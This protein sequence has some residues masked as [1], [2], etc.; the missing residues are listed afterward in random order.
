MVRQRGA[1][2]ADHHYRGATQL[3]IERVHVRLVATHASDVLGA[4]RAGSR[5]AFVA[6]SGK[7]LFP[8][9]AAPEVTG[10]TLVAVVDAILATGHPAVTSCRRVAAPPGPRTT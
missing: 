7:A 6:R 10:A 1:L 3:G 9:G 2:L 4:L 5:A 8:I